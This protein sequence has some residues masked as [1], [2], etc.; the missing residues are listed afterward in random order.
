VSAAASGTTGDFAEF[1]VFR[2]KVFEVLKMTG[3]HEN[4]TL[5]HDIAR[6]AAEKIP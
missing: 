2:G 5:L 3:P 1:I 4:A 6:K